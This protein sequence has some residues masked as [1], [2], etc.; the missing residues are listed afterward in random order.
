MLAWFRGR[1]WCEHVEQGASSGNLAEVL[2][3]KKG[4]DWDPRERA[5]RLRLAQ[6]NLCRGSLVLV[7]IPNPKTYSSPMSRRAK[8][9]VSVLR[10]GSAIANG[11][12]WRPRIKLQSVLNDRRNQYTETTRRRPLARAKRSGHVSPANSRLIAPPARI[13]SMGPESLP[14]NRTSL[15]RPMSAGLKR[16]GRPVD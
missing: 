2:A 1:G 10:F 12:S 6:M 5:K 8:R 9:R 16:T 7:N 3:L 4:S 11:W 14:Q 13:P 15:P